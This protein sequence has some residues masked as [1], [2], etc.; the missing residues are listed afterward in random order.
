MTGFGTGEASRPG[1]SVRV[2]LR[3]TNYR[4]FDASIRV[5]RSFAGWENRVREIVSARIARGRLTVNVE[6]ESRQPGSG[7]VLDEK[8]AGEYAQVIQ[9][10]RERFQVTGGIDPVAFTQLPDVLR[11]DGATPSDVGEDVLVEAL[12]AALDE[13]DAMRRSEGGALAKDLEGRIRKME[14]SLATLERIAQGSPDRF[15][16]RLQERIAVLVPAGLVPDERIAAEVA[17]LAEK[18]D[19]VEEIVRFRAHIEAFL[20][21]LR[22]REPVGRRLDF[23]LQE[24]NREANTIGSKALSA[25]ISH[26]VVEIKEEIE[27]LREQV[28]NIE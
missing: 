28:Q 21:F 23:L 18:A 5:S 16:R 13:L 11:R 7:V 6:A 9:F 14:G 22:R 15:R 3:S 12:G 24:M 26:Q 17:L 10:L 2:E 27:R 19:I 1:V 8:I 20:G 25:E 4:Y